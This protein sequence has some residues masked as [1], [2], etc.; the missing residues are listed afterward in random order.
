[1]WSYTPPLRDMQFVMEELLSVRGVW[2]QMPR[3]AD[4]DA[5]TAPQILEESGKFAVQSLAPTNA[6]GDLQGCHYED[7]VVR[8]PEGFAE[9]YRRYCEAGWPGLA[10]DAAWGGQGLPQIL[11]TALYEMLNATNHAWAMYP[12][13]SQG[14]YE[15]LRAHASEAIKAEY[16]PK[17]VS[18]EWLITMCLTE[19]QAGSDVGLIRT[20][21]EPRADGSYAITGSKIF[22]SGGEHDLTQNIVHLVLARLPGAPLG[23]RGISLFLVPKR[24]GGAGSQANGVRCDGIEKKMGIKGSA[25]C[26]MSFAA[27]QGWLIGEP[28]RG[29]A[30]MF[31]MMNSARLNVGLQG[32]GHAEMAYQNALRYASERVQSRAVTRPPNAGA[33]HPSGADPILFQPAVRR[34]LLT[35]RAFVEGERALAYW[36]AQLLD[37]AEYHADAGQR[38]Q[39][40]DL[41]S[42]LTPVA[43]GFLTENGFALSSAALQLWGGHG[44]IHDNGI[45]QTVRDSRIAMIYEGTNEIQA[46]DLLVRKVIGDGGR[47]FGQL[48][49]LVGA[50][51]E[52]CAA[53]PGCERFAEA[54]GALQSNLVKVT[55]DLV[56][57]AK[58][59]P[60]LAP[61][62]A[63]DF[64]RLVG[65]VLLGSLWARAARLAIPRAADAFYAAKRETA[66][67]F[68]DQLLPESQWR[69]EL[70]NRRRCELPWVEVPR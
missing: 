63:P 5:D 27:A 41:V 1:M 15:C 13:L 11:N 22:I 32:L 40:H 56:A 51:A 69:L 24:L 36:C 55:G 25:T 10:C 16:L 62:I 70:V 59:A 2:A 39:A 20:R 28:N 21:A 50:E 19:S 17:I 4:L 58:E 61:R 6:S 54:L 9:V 53:S 47:K 34:T 38:A 65:L 66:Q 42:L 29:L 30:A 3:F 37:V 48:L 49:Q 43:K 64:L 52:S 33:P 35:L 18:G 67:F 44:Y 57:E 31:V 60:E 7:G 23:T 8:T 46:I 12:G 26:A 68:F 14:A 45:E